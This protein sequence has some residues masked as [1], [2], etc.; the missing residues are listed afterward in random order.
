[1]VWGVI[2]LLLVVSENLSL[3]F[4]L[5]HQGQTLRSARTAHDAMKILETIA[6]IEGV[7]L[8][9]RIENCKSVSTYIQKE[10]PGLRVVS[11]QI[12]ERNSPFKRVAV[13]T[14]PLTF[15]KPLVDTAEARFVWDA[16]K[17]RE[18]K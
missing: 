5:Q 4:L 18:V 14:G 1:M 8:D 6:A 12:A 7:I 16:R 17:R 10:R 3:A 9:E 15:P 2:S 11:W 13:D